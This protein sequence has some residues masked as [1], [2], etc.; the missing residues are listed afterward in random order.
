MAL[1]IARPT[2]FFATCKNDRI[3][4]TATTASNL[5]PIFVGGAGRSGTTLLRVIL[6]THPRIVCGPELKVT[7]LICELWHACQFGYLPALE[8]HHLT[9]DDL[10][11]SFRNLIA[12][13][14]E[15]DC[16]VAG[17]P[18]VAEKSPNNVFFF[19][20][21]N[22]LFPDSPLIHVIRDGR[23]VVCSLTRMNWRSAKT[24]EPLESTRDAS[25]AAMYWVRAV[26]AA[27]AAAQ[28]I[29]ALAQRYFELRYEQL[30][31]APE[32]TLR[33]LFAF[34]GEEWD[35]RVLHYHERFR[36]LGGESSAGQVSR[37]I[38]TRALA[39]WKTDLSEADKD[40]VKQIAGPLLLELGYVKDQN[41]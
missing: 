31:A 39:R 19:A 8:H 38:N 12:S 25:S 15:K 34:L 26:S 21:L 27:R 16:A 6:D 9:A 33:P 40:A 36:N 17:K 14:L 41:W 5:A 32:E 23:D 35:S 20:H 28:Q 2:A 22:R 37:P 7:P 18:R 24:G 3:R 11:Q 4:M 29:P 10:A 30:I 1:R 13:L